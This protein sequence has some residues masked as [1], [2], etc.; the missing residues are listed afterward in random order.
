[1]ESRISEVKQSNKELE[2]SHDEVK[3]EKELL[4][5]EL[6]NELEKLKMNY[7]HL[8]EDKENESQTLNDK[9]RD[10]ESFYEKEVS[11]KNEA[12]AAADSNLLKMREELEKLQTLVLKERADME[13]ILSEKDFGKQVR[14]TVP[15]RVEFTLRVTTTLT[16]WWTECA[17]IDVLCVA[18]LIIF[19]LYL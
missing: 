14:N 17:F 16:W 15:F 13:V 5:I 3:Y 6:N 11:Q 18:D 12:I 19:I 9:I 1:M 8:K 4:T 10:L 7:K 2:T